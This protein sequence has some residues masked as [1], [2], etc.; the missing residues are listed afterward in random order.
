MVHVKVYPKCYMV[1]VCNLFAK[2]STYLN[3]ASF[4][5]IGKCFHSLQLVEII[6]GFKLLIH[7]F[8]LYI[9]VATLWFSS[10][11]LCHISM[12]NN[13]LFLNISVEDKH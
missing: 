8:N 13:G 1:R 6:F 9:S 4:I 3:S 12:D 5:T 7:C 10:A 11:N 2:N